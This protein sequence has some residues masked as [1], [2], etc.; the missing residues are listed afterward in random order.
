MQFLDGS[1]ERIVAVFFVKM[2]DQ[3]MRVVK[4]RLDAYP[5]LMEKWSG[6][7]L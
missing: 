6:V 2:Y 5:K 7:P 3:E 1:G 4:E